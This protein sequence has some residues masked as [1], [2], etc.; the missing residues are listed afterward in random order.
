MLA[1]SQAAP[2]ITSLD[3]LREY[4]KD[5]ESLLKTQERLLILEA[6]HFSDHFQNRAAELLGESYRAFNYKMK[7]HGIPGRHQW[8]AA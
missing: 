2:I 4:Q 7:S 3:F 1:K 6:L 5:G 8:S